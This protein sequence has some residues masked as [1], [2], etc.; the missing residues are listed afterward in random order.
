MTFV[1]NHLARKAI[2]INIVE[3][4]T[5]VKCLMFVALV[6]QETQESEICC[7]ILDVFTYK[8]SP[9]VSEFPEQNIYSSGKK[10]YLC[11][12]F[13]SKLTRTGKLLLHIRFSHKYKAHLV[14]ILSEAIP[15]KKYVVKTQQ[16]PHRPKT[17]VM[18]VLWQNFF[19]QG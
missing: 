12:T 17:S 15:E 18:R 16:N 3:E 4:F 2:W 8:N 9:S 14:C 6:V 10:P 7:F 13:G 11:G 1:L 19:S 5:Q